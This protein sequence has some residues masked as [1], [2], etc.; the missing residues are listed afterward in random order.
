M[1]GAGGG[2]ARDYLREE[3]RD[4]LERHA[5]AEF[6]REEGVCARVR[7]DAQGRAQVEG[8]V[9]DGGGVLLDAQV[10]EVLF[11]GREEAR[12]AC[13]A[14][15]VEE[16]DDGE[17]ERGRAFDDEEVAPPLQARVDFCSRAAC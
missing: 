11:C 13:C 12:A 17:E 1:H 16:G 15:E 5:D 4:G 2:E 8:L 14:R 9:D 6:E 7:E 10:R 3:E